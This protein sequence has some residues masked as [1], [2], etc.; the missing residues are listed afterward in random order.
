MFDFESPFTG[1][2]VEEATEIR[3][4]EVRGQHVQV[5]ARM[6]RCTDTGELFTT[7]EQDQAILAGMYRAWRE[8]NRVPAPARITA[9]RLQLGLSARDASRLLGFGINQFGQYEAGELPSESNTLLLRFF[10][11]PQM[12]RRLLNERVDVLPLRAIR[13]LE[14]ACQVVARPVPRVVSS[15]VLNGGNW[16]GPGLYMTSPGQESVASANIS[17]R[18]A[19]SS[20]H[21][22]LWQPEGRHLA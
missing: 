14:K 20:F 10:C 5:E 15:L 9:R 19:P 3:T 8:Q 12:L 4:Y 21:T 17:S 22:D 18:Y 7:G 11:D 16:S 2:R 6:C 13:K 1:G